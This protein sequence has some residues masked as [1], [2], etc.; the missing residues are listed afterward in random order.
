MSTAPLT[1]PA[2][3]S[4]LTGL[5]PTHHGIR[6]NGAAALS[7]DPYTLAERLR[8]RGWQTGAFVSAIVL[9]HSFGLDQGFSTYDDGPFHSD[10]PIAVPARDGDD[11]ISAASEWLLESERQAD[12][13]F[14]WV[15]LYD[16]HQ[17]YAP[18]ADSKQSDP[19]LAEVEWADLEL[20]RLLELYRTL[21][22]KRPM[23]LSVLGDHGE[24]RGD[25]GESTHGWF[26]Y[27]S[28]LRVPWIHC[29]PNGSPQVG[30]EVRSIIDL[31]PTLLDEAGLTADDMDG[32]PL[33]QSVGDRAAYGETWIPFHNFGYSPLFVL[34]DKARRYIE[35]PR[36]ELYDWAK[37]PGELH[38]LE[39]TT[40]RARMARDLWAMGPMDPA[41]AVGTPVDHLTEQLLALGYTAALDEA[42]P[43]RL[44]ELVD[45]KDHATA[46]E[47]A[48]AQIS[49]ARAL[50]PSRGVP[51][52]MEALERA[53]GSTLLRITAARGLA[54]LDRPDEAVAMLLDGQRRPSWAARTQA[55][56]TLVEANRAEDARKLLDQMRAEGPDNKVVAFLEAELLRRARQPEA[57]LARLEAAGEE[58]S[59]SPGMELVAGACLQDLGKLEESIPPL[60]RSLDQDPSNAD[61]RALL[62]T[63]LAA[64]GD[65]EGARQVADGARSPIGPHT[66]LDLLQA[67]LHLA[68][69][70][71]NGAWEILDRSISKVEAPPWQAF[72]MMAEAGAQTNR[73]EATLRQVRAQAEAAGA[74]TGWQEDLRVEP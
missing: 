64:G 68:L 34:E 10:I 12:P 36:P 59:W 60:R 41:R 70:D 6:D 32:L 56:A 3:S 67:Q 18:R 7:Q 5:L 24:S 53:P 33:D 4:I 61:A 1:L 46:T 13:F 62:A 37:D 57:A 23:V 47:E 65:L 69:G 9:E 17:P 44:D 43:Q 30:E 26:V 27:R 21:G 39:E 14:L 11:T 25:H 28:T 16:P 63:A 45:P 15:H 52:L 2:H 8:D 73:P 38:P 29:S 42:L 50:P 54:L 20:H 49:A 35:A 40:T 58:G 66:E 19:Y 22:R 31:A 48:S 55:A 71:P 74:P 51:M 72:A